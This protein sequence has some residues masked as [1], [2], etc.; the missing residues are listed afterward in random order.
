M[1][2]YHY[3]YLIIN[4]I[5]LKLYVGK[6]ST[7]DLNDGY[8]GSGVELSKSIRKYGKCNFEK[9]ILTY[10]KNEQEA[11]QKEE[12]YI[13]IAKSWDNGQFLNIHQG[14]AINQLEGIRSMPINPKTGKRMSKKTGRDTGRPTFREFPKDWEEKYQLY[15][16]GTLKA[17]Q[18]QSLYNWPKSTFYYMIK[19]Y[20][21]AGVTNE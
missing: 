2:K 11:F 17:K 1:I 4:K 6:H 16:D 19:Q 7:N 20:E 14:G 8:F 15:K 5:N 13:L 21:K 12:Q 9:I 10:C 18:M 3:V